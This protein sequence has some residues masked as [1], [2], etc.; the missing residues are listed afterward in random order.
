MAIFNIRGKSTVINPPKRRWLHHPTSLPKFEAAINA[1][2]PI[3]G[4]PKDN[5]L[6]GF[7]LFIL[8]AFEELN[9]ISLHD[10]DNYYEKV[11][12]LELLA[13][14]SEEIGGLEVTDVVTLI[15]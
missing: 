2:T 5:D 10:E 13:H 11:C 12:P 7:R 4:Q 14:F 8:H 3:V 15:G 6:Q 1:F 9:Y